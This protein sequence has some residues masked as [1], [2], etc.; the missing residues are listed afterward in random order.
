MI[1]CLVILLPLIP[2][3]RS[4]Y[5]FFIEDDLNEHMRWMKC[6]QDSL[7]HFFSKYFTSIQTSAKKAVVTKYNLMKGDMVAFLP[8]NQIFNRATMKFK[9][10]IEHKLS[11][12]NIDGVSRTAEILYNNSGTMDE[13][14]LEIAIGKQ[15]IT[16]RRKD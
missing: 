4:A 11:P 10:G 9:F 7:D 12:P 1:G 15:V 3:K 14:G 2:S 13:F 8:T 16:I 5:L 6:L